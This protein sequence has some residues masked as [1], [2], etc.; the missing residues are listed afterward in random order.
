[1]TYFVSLIIQVSS[2][3]QGQ[4][5]TYSGLPPSLLGQ[6]PAAEWM[7]HTQTLPGVLAYPNPYNFSTAQ[8]RTHYP[9]PGYPSQPWDP[10]Q[11]AVA[12][13]PYFRNPNFRVHRQPPPA[14]TKSSASGVVSGWHPFPSHPPPSLTN[15]PLMTSVPPPPLIRL[16]PPKAFARSKPSKPEGPQPAAA[17]K[18]SHPAPEAPPPPQN[19]S[20]P[21][22]PSMV[23]YQKDWSTT[24]QPF[25][26]YRRVNHR[27]NDDPVKKV[28]TDSDFLS[29]DDDDDEGKLVIDLDGEA[30]TRHTDNG[31]S[32]SETGSVN[33]D[34]KAD[35][36]SSV[37]DVD[38]RSSNSQGTQPGG[39]VRSKT[40][41]ASGGSASGTT[42]SRTSDDS[43][44]IEIEMLKPCGM[45]KELILEIVVS[46]LMSKIDCIMAVKDI[47]HYMESNYP[48]FQSAPKD[49]WHNWVRNVLLTNDC[50]IKIAT[51]NSGYSTWTIQGKYKRDLQRGSFERFKRRM[52]QEKEEAEK[53]KD[54]EWRRHF[55]EYQSMS[56]VTKWQSWQGSQQLGVQAPHNRWKDNPSRSTTSH[57]GPPPSFL[58]SANQPPNAAQ[59]KVASGDVE[60]GEMTSVRICLPSLSNPHAT[61]EE[62]TQEMSSSLANLNLG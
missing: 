14:H 45:P 24:E 37:S 33:E 5:P 59:S 12:L 30:T 49:E 36:G 17:P 11:Y 50:F 60:V 56:T 57:L 18:L 21:L 4:Q 46:A 23:K 3:L 44:V 27:K 26:R 31:V 8:G 9:W 58:A 62:F 6:Y 1:M 19:S 28:L 55:A 22:D 54:N 41:E 47:Y 25:R 32:Q 51:R 42:S 29:S 43:E 10:W 16:H 2:L 52:K 35:A 34:L 61:K 53:R 13:S 48:Y 20:K 7:R 38:S 15:M 39:M 40:S